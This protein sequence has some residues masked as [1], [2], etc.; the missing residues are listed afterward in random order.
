MQ[1]DCLGGSIIPMNRVVALIV[2]ALTFAV[3]NAEAG[4]ICATSHDA[5]SSVRPSEA[6][7]RSLIVAEFKKNTDSEHP[8]LTHRDAQGMSGSTISVSSF[9]PLIA[10][11]DG[12]A[13]SYGCLALAS[14]LCLANSV[15][16]PCPDLDG[17][18]R[19]PQHSVAFV[20]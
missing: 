6:V 9:A 17:I 1:V 5:L 8:F 16:P 12:G 18:L 3:S 11:S 14:R 10:L 15:L 7:L 20:F 13:H 2:L 4:F 19:P